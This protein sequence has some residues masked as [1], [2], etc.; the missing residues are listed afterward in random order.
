MNRFAEEFELVTVASG[1]RSLRSRAHA[2]TFHPVIGPMAEARA[3]HVEQ[4]RL[5]ERAA[6]A[7]GGFVVWD[8]GLGAA[9]NAIAV[10]EAFRDFRGGPVVLH[11]FDA[12][13]A[14]L[15]FAV[16]HA[17]ALGYIA[18]HHSAVE[19]LLAEGCAVCGAVQW[20]LHR[21]D[22]RA[23][24]GAVSAPDAILYDPYS[25]RAN[26]E[27]WTL[28]HFTALAS[29]LDPARPCLWSNY[30]RSTAVRV[31]LLLAG[32]FVGRGAASG[33]K[34]ETTLAA[35]DP[36]LLLAPLER[37]WLERVRRST[38]S[39]PL[40]AGGKGGPIEPDDWAKLGQ[41]PQFGA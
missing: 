26:P 41:H 2:E 40:R 34:D 23:Q 8:V 11:S 35:N 27:L 9:A 17:D 6:L 16:L 3:L 36:T 39:A 1:A 10:I 29:R 33:E 7:D 4:Q 38:Q 28:E 18:P 32:F 12:T 31:T 15:Q 30:T 21:G 14:P 19:T 22:F 25:P 13:S 5:V 24:F 37:A 20:R